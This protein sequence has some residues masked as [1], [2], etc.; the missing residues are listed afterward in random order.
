MPNNIQ[1]DCT[2]DVVIFG[3][4]GVS[5]KQP[6][7]NGHGQQSEYEPPNKEWERMAHLWFVSQVIQ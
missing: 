1:L 5:S 4:I 6:L 3:V 2:V 7:I